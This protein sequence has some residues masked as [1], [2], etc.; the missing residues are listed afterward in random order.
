MPP[1]PQ[2]LPLLSLVS[3][4]FSTTLAAWQIP[5]PSTTSPSRSAALSGKHALVLY[6]YTS[7]AVPSLIWKRTKIL[8]CFWVPLTLCRMQ[9]AETWAWAR[10]KVII[11]NVASQWY[12]YPTDDMLLPLS[13]SSFQTVHID[14]NATF[15]NVRLRSL[16]TGVA[17][18]LY[19]NASGWLFILFKIL[20]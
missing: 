18:V 8:H 5:P 17:I 10:G 13:S 19:S 9:P 1:C 12:F 16:L 7:T 20:I 14:K 3:I 6:I 11:V 4:L 15:L 2:L